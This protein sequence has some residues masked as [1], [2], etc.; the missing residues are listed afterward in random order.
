VDERQGVV[1]LACMLCILLLPPL[2][3]VKVKVKMKEEL[4]GFARV[5]GT[6]GPTREL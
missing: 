6:G 1:L 5:H 4:L 3:Q 2:S